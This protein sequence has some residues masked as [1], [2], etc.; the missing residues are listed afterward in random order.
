M[1]TSI[2][3]AGWRKSRRTAFLAAV[4][5]LSLAAMAFGRGKPDSPGGDLLEFIG[6][7]QTAGGKE[8]DPQLLREETVPAAAGK[9]KPPGDRQG[10]ADSKKGQEKDTK[11]GQR[12]E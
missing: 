3:T 9:K 7:F 10:R 2:S 4:M 11:K 5:L 12:D 6:T 8:I 1:K